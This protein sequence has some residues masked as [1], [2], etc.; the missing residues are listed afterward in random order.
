MAECCIATMGSCLPQGEVEDNL[1]SRDRWHALTPEQINRLPLLQYS[2][3]IWIVRERRAL[4]EAV[5]QLEGESLLG[6]DTETQPAFRRGESYPPAL[7][8]LAGA[9]GVYVFLLRDVGLPVEVTDILAHPGIVKAGIAV[10]RDV[11]ELQ[12]L[13]EFEPRAFVDLGVWA[14]AA[15]IPHHGLRGL[16]ALLLGGRVPKQA[17]LT[18][19]A[20]PQLPARA[21]RY[22][23]TD[24]WVSRRLYRVM[25]RAGLGNV[26]G[27]GQVNALK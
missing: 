13:A 19:W 27:K 6:F 14:E 9:S 11:K 4:E 17:R 1:M 25:E 2:G 23:A 26:W 20:L 21:L 24:A 15:G 3:P 5:R 16:A 22:A 7:L 18:N 8:Q 10:T 12:T